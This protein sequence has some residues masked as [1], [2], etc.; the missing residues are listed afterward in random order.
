MLSRRKVEG[1]VVRDNLNLSSSN[2]LGGLTSKQKN[3]LRTALD[4][5]YYKKPRGAN[6]IKVAS[7]MGIPRS[8]FVDHLRK[9]ENK[10]LNSLHPF[11]SLEAV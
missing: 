3:A 7:A 2:L 11:I 5:G 9:A 10:I 6:A 1:D 8:S 4:I